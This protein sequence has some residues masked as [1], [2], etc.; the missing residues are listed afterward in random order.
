MHNFQ[1]RHPI[2][3]RQ[4]AVRKDQVNATAFERRHKVIL[5]MHASDGT[6][7]APAFQSG[8]NERGIDRIIFQVQNVEWDDS[9]FYPDFTQTCGLA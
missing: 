7:N 5:V 3:G 4:R 2:E 8:L 9:F 1:R 6:R